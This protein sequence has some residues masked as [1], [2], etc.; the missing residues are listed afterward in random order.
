MNTVK[1]IQLAVANLPKE[2]LETFETWFENF[3]FEVWDEKIKKD[4]TKGF[5]ANLVNEAISEYKQGKTF[6][7]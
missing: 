3:Y 2:D 1:E 6:E 7:L 4:I 5:L